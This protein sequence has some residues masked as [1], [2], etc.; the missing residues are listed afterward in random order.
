MSEAPSAIARPFWTPRLRATLSGAAVAAVLATVYDLTILPGSISSGDVAKFQFVGYALGTPHATGYPVYTLLTF[1]LTRSLSAL[2]GASPA[3]VV[4]WVSAICTI[5]AALAVLG[6]LSRLGV[7]RV[8]A[9]GVALAVSLTPTIW[10]NALYAE[11]YPL[12]LL[13]MSA[14]LLCAVD[15]ESTRREWVLALGIAVY[16]LSLGHHLTSV[17]LAPALILFLW[18]ADRRVFRIRNLAIAAA[19]LCGGLLSYGYLLYRYYAPDTSYLETQVPDLPTLLWYLTGA[20]FRGRLFGYSFVEALTARPL[21][22]AVH[23]ARELGPLVPFAAAGLWVLSARRTGVLLLGYLATQVLFAINYRI[24][25]IES[26]FAPCVLV[27]GL[28]A[29]AGLDFVLERLPR[30]FGA[31]AGWLS[32]LLPL[33]LLG[34]HH[35]RVDQSRNTGDA[36][37]MERILR[38]VDQ[39]ALILAD[40]YDN[41]EH[42]RYF[43]YAKGW[44]ERNVFVAGPV[45]TCELLLAVEK[46][47]ERH[48]VP[49]QFVFQ[50]QC[51]VTVERVV[52]YLREGRPFY[53]YES[54]RDIP[55]GLTLYGLGEDQ[56]VRL[57]NAGLNTVD[58]G[59]GLFRLEA[60]PPPA[61]R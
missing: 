57:A 45:A 49:R 9:V 61:S 10:G 37:R 12:H 60:A 21:L 39:D 19:L 3:L 53:L 50:N 7:Q 11:V 8:P 14:T 30:R 28:S 5:A 13:L 48:R 18:R 47:L 20:Q 24:P 29:G 1:A 55:K 4:N 17:L 15:W 54:R 25:D 36:P 32:L 35:G 43:L 59:D 44:R 27:L 56:R 41:G 51:L 46:F 16:A 42:L 40:G 38:T 34:A 23:L 6:L 52:G 31:S 26:Y 33:V 22:G 58:L 2:F